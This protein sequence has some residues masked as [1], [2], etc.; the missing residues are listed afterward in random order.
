MTTHQLTR[1]QRRERR[2]SNKP[3]RGA[4][5]A[6]GVVLGVLLSLVMTPGVASASACT[7]AEARNHMTCHTP[8]SV[9]RCVLNVAG[10][11]AV[12]AAFGGPL[13]FLAGVAGGLVG[14]AVSAV[15]Y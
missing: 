10:A 6:F 13:G 14:C 8:P 15:D 1:S 3:L 4:I 2:W 5:A 11:G 9:S 12:G 7:D